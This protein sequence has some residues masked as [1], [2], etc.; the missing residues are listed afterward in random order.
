MK[1]NRIRT[2]NPGKDGTKSLVKKYGKNLI[3]VRYR[4]NA[5][6]KECVKTVELVVERKQWDPDHKNSIPSNKI[7][8]IRVKY[9]EIQVGRLVRQAGG[10]WNRAKKVWELRYDQIQSLGLNDRIIE[11]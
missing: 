11:E 2:L 10:V 8:P 9:G 4:Y 6:N 3:C 5:A 7:L 1:E